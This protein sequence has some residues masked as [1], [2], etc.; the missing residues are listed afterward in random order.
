MEHK[1]SV[2]FMDGRTFTVGQMVSFD[3]DGFEG[4]G[5]VV[6]VIQPSRGATRVCVHVQRLTIKGHPYP[7]K[8]EK[9]AECFYWFMK[10]ARSRGLPGGVLEHLKVD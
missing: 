9:M 8:T 2:T 5:H 3:H 1:T 6:D 4:E 7:P 10:A